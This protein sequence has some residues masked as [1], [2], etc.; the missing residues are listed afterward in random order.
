MT[1]RNNNLEPNAMFKMLKYL[2][3]QDIKPVITIQ[4]QALEKMI[5]QILFTLLI[6]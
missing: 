3:N 4:Y 1:V 2:L 5:M 6:N